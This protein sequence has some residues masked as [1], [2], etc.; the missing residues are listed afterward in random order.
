MTGLSKETLLPRLAAHLL[1]QGLAGASLRPMAR[2][3][4]TS[5]R[6][7]IYHFGTKEELIVETLGVVAADLSARLDT[8]LPPGPANDMATLAGQVLMVIRA[9]AAAG[10]FRIWLEVL[11]DPERQALA[12]A[13]LDGFHGWVAAH[14]PQG[15]PDPEGSAAALLTFVEGAVILEAAGRGAVTDRAIGALFGSKD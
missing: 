4:G 13:I 8:A 9:P 11:S 6:M 10:H 7:L 12:G 3:A 1:D 2:A 14:L 15:L 5:D